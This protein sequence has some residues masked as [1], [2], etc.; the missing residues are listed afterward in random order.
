MQHNKPQ[1]PHAAYFPSFAL[2]NTKLRKE[3]NTKIQEKKLGTLNPL[4]IK[5]I[6]LRSFAE[7]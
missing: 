6:L 1:V 7:L 5:Q 2:E 4:K 3:G